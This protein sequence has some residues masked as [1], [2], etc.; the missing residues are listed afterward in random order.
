MFSSVILLHTIVDQLYGKIK[1]P[2]Q[3]PNLRKPSR[4]RFPAWRAGTT[5]LF[6]VPACQAKWAGGIDSWAP[7]T[8]TKS[9]SGPYR[10][11]T[12]LHNEQFFYN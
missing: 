8:F 5:T 9:G 1:V 4:D 3:R 6:D 10:T 12:V 11:H 2:A 7:L